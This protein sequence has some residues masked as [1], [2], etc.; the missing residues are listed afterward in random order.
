MREQIDVMIYN[1]YGLSY[2][3]ACVI[4]NGLSEADYERKL[5]KIG[6]FDGSCYVGINF[7]LIICVA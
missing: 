2:E 3:E 1:L 6:Q 4:D 7:H 5:Y